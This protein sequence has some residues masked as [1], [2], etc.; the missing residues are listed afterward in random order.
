MKNEKMRNQIVIIPKHLSDS[1]V[2]FGPFYF[3]D[4]TVHVEL[5][6]AKLDMA[7]NLI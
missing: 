7:L 1:T 4:S 5:P 2:M 6:D 3:G